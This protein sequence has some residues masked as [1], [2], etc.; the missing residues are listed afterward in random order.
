VTKM[1][2]Q[3]K[4]IRGF[5]LVTVDDEF[6]EIK[7][8]YFD[9]LLWKVRYVVVDTIRW[10]PGKKVLI[11][12][13]DVISINEDDEKISFA[14]TKDQIKNSP[15][16]DFDKPLSRQ[17]ETEMVKY[18]SWPRYWEEKVKTGDPNLRS[19]KEITG[20]VVNADDEKIGTAENVIIDDMDW[21]VRY[22]VV[23][24]YSGK[25]VLLATDWILN[26]DEDKKV[27]KAD[28]LKEHVEKAPEYRPEDKFDREHEKNLYE[29]YEK[30]TYW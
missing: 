12:P 21:T 13:S 15:P 1:L 30:E 18:Y 19:I 16:I 3:T 26:M 10:L 11:S 25:K 27:I 29:I 28:V 6:G 9:D 17:N 24:L 5:K 7:D 4:E 20:Y 23:K 22:I 2:R 14:L 8:F